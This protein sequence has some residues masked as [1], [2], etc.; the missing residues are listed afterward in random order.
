M[1]GGVAVIFLCA[2]LPAVADQQS[3]NRDD[4]RNE[5]AARALGANAIPAG[6]MPRLADGKPDLSG[7][8]FGGG[9]AGNIEEG[10]APG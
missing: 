3:R 10:L 7:V 4:V 8:W 9:P 6:P 5:A 2:S 1:R